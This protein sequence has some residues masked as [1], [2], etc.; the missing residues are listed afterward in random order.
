MKKKYEEPFEAFFMKKGVRAIFGGVQN[1]FGFSRRALGEETYETRPKTY[2]PS[3]SS[4]KRL[5]IFTHF[6]R[7]LKPYYTKTTTFFREHASHMF[8]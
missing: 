3:L 8:H 4:L 1:G 7:L 6:Q 5:F 2:T